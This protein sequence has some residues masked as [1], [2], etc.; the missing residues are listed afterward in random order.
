MAATGFRTI[1]L[2]GDSQFVLEKLAG[3]AGI[4]PGHLLAISSGALIKHATADGVVQNLVA[5]T[6]QTATGTGLTIDQAYASGDTVYYTQGRSGDVLYMWLA[7]ANTTVAG[8]SA[9]GSN[10]DGTLKVVTVGASTLEDSVVGYA[11]EVVANSSGAAVRLR[12][13]IR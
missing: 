4:K 1:V 8:V 2:Q 11:E 9:L 6:S 13:R 5:V 3:E 10:G 7:T 12:V